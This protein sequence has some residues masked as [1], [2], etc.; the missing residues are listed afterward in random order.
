MR[1]MKNYSCLRFQMD[2]E[3]ETMNMLLEQVKNGTKV[4]FF[5]YD[6]IDQLILNHE[7]K[8]L[9]DSFF[10]MRLLLMNN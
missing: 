10:Y 4:Y 7:V 3:P 5:T 9:V 2:I 1:V 8:K 6:P